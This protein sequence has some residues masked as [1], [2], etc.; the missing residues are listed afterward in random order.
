MMIQNTVEPERLGAEYRMSGPVPAAQLGMPLLLRVAVRNTGVA[1]WP[2]Q[3]PHPINLAY[4]WLDAQGH[5]V[6]FDGVRA[7]LPAPLPPGETIELNLHVE[8]PPRAGA[9]VLSL[10]MVEEGISWFS[11]RGVAPLLIPVSVAPVPRDTPRACIICQIAMIND[12][13]GNH[14]V[15]QLRFFLARGYQ[16]LVLVAQVD[17]RQPAEVRQHMAAVSPDDLRVGTVTPLNRRA[18]E[19]FHSSDI[20]V[21]H[22]PNYY[23]LLESIAWVDR[24]VIIV[25]Y[26]GVT[27]PH[28]WA[29]EG[30]EAQA[31]GQQRLELVRYA[32]YAIA[33]SAF[34]RDELIQR[35]VIA[36]ERVFVNA[37]V[38]PIER[39]RPGPRPAELATRYALAADQPVLLYVGRMAAN[40]RIEDL[41]RALVYV[42]A[43][44]PRA[45][46]LLVGDDRTAHYAQVVA[47]ARRLAMA[48]GVADG[49]IFTG[50]VPD[51]ELVAHYQLA[52]LFVTA[53]L[54]EGFCIP[55]VEAM[56]CGVPV[57]GAHATVLPDTIGPAGVTFRPED[58]ADMAEKILI[59]L[60]ERKLPTGQRSE[61]I[62]DV[63]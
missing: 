29:G 26:H 52:D 20:Y 53:S 32:D 35:G 45:A 30:Y 27:P 1:T 39:F 49:V 4:H 60:A 59:L 38:V 33:H 31:E 2:N 28:L 7:I 12:A 18:L 19:Y 42:R 17:P 51:E 56:A 11:M 23:P 3:Q 58:P 44:H 47:E 34:M 48:L 15:N 10:D 37:L 62:I 21:F 22:Y 40:K 5:M 14:V 54:H 50:Q 24:G 6:T 46:L 57:V 41:V 55:V 8:P 13:V 61:E 36:P 16:A 63:A 43:H 9:Y 25:D